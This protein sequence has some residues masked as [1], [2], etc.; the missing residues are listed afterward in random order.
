MNSPIPNHYDPENARQLVELA[1]DAYLSPSSLSSFK[2]HFIE[3][4]TTDS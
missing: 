1:A 3:S 2:S 4:T